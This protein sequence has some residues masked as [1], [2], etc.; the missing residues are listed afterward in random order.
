MKPL[1]CRACGQFG[2][3][4]NYWEKKYEGKCSLCGCKNEQTR[5]K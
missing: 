3:R 5:L 2:I 4:Y 1:Y